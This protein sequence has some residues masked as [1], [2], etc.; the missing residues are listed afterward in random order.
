MCYSW[1]LDKLMSVA[2]NKIC[3]QT[4]KKKAACSLHRKLGLIHVAVLYFSRSF[5]IRR[6]DNQNNNDNTCTCK[7]LHSRHDKVSHDY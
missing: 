6:V 7:L 5:K 1:R 3:A 4:S 2:H